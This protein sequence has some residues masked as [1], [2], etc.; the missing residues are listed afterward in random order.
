MKNLNRKT[1]SLN[2]KELLSVLKSG[3]STNVE[4]M[5]KEISES[6]LTFS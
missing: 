6:F 5:I 3:E 4:K 2:E 1:S